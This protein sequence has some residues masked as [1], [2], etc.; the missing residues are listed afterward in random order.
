[1]KNKIIFA[2]ILVFSPLLLF[3]Q[4]IQLWNNFCTS[5]LVPNEDIVVNVDIDSI[6]VDSCETMLFYSIDDQQ[7]WSYEDMQ[8]LFL[9]GY[10]NTLSDTLGLPGSGFLHYGLQSNFHAWLDT[11]FLNLYLSMTPENSLDLFPTPDNYM[12]E[13]CQEETGDNTGS[14]FLDLTE[15]WASY[16]DDKFYFTLNN[17]DTEW[18]LYETFSFLP[19]WYVYLVGLINPETVDSIG[20]AL[21]Y[22]DIPSFAGFPGVQTGLY[23]GDIT[24]SSY[25]RI[26]DIQS[27]VY[28]GKL[29]MACNIDDLTSDPQFGPWPNSY[30]CLVLDAITATINVDPFITL[31]DSTPPVLFYPT[32]EERVIG[33]NTPPQLSDLTYSSDNDSITFFITYTDTD[34]N[35]PLVHN[36][37]IDLPD[38][39]EFEMIPQD[40]SYETGS[41]FSLTLPSS[42]ITSHAQAYFDDGEYEVQSNILYIT[43]VYDEI[44]GGNLSISAFPNPFSRST[45]VKF[46]KTTELTGNTEIT[47]YNIKGQLI[48]ILTSFPNPSLGMVEVTWDGV[49]QSGNAVASGIYLCTITCENRIIDSQKLLL[50][51]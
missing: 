22:A 29:Y 12:I 48:K 36:I 49:D 35:L 6:S 14:S 38:G 5:A 25:T 4:N 44:P 20:Y 45:T 42:Q 8:S 34:N 9:P 47:I 27:Q 43:S 30:G 46:N 32:H 41:L 24:D 1:M 37:M 13:V 39:G 19:P 15:F 2:F 33:T 18:P 21:V 10:M 51:R 28:N 7:N 23:K 17:N 3:A 26:G 40:H 16:S 31:N 50:L 11:L